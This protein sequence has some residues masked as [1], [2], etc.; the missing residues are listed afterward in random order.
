M[1][2]SPRNW[3]SPE[4][5]ERILMI[6]SKKQ[7]EAII[8]WIGK[9]SKRFD[10]IMEMMLRREERIAKSA[11]WI[12]GHVGER[13][14]SLVEPWLNQML[15][16]IQGPDCLDAVKRAIIRALQFQKIP[17]KAQG[18]V[19]NIC[20][21]MLGD[22]SQPIAARVFA[23]SILQHITESEPDLRHEVAT[24]IRRMI[25]YSTSAFSARARHVLKKMGLPKIED[26]SFHA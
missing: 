14:P 5:E 18:I 12:V 19:F 9:D 8:R 3:Q 23:M 11:A 16:R 13:H 1:S 2:R 21:Q 7:V 24:L 25:P 10:A 22:L 4:L 17:R 6:R 20:F 15:K 26:E